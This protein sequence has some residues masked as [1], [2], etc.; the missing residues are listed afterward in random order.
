MRNKRR[1]TTRR[2]VM[3]GGAPN[4]APALRFPGDNFN[5]QDIFN[6]LNN[7]LKAAYSINQAA[8]A[9]KETSDF[10][11]NPGTTNPALTGT[12]IIQKNSAISFST[13]ASSFINS[14]KGVYGSLT[15]GNTMMLPSSSAPASSA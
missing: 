12:R 10:Q 9:I 11:N 8:Q 7:Y 4:P 5:P 1:S 3:Y 15:S 14:L 2:R 6:A 13:A